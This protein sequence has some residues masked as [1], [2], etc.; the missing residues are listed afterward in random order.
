MRMTLCLPFIHTYHFVTYYRSWENTTDIERCYVKVSTDGVS[1][2]D[3]TTLGEDEGQVF[4][5]G[6]GS[7]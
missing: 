3:P 4:I 5:G 6:E 7:R 2:P 1:W